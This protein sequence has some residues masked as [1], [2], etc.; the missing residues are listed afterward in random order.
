[1]VSNFARDPAGGDRD[2][3]KAVAAGEGDIAIVNSYYFAQ[4]IYSDKKKV[5]KDLK[6]HFPA[7][8]SMGV[9]LNV[10]G[11][12]VMKNA[13]NVY[14][15]VKFIEFLAS[16]EAQKI[17]SYINFEYPVVDSIGIPETLKSWGNF[18]PDSV[19]TASY[20]KNNKLAIKI[21]DRVGWN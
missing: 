1:L 18:Y 7:D 3:I 9:H 4:L 12:G 2:Q 17:Y 11:A 21:A 13:P 10:S 19:P 15:A 20:G 6:V 14:S 5:F 8:E 16:D